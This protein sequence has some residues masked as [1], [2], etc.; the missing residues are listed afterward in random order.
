MSCIEL[1]N[2]VK[3]YG[4]RL[5]VDNLSLAIEAGEI[6]GLLGPNGAGKSTTI[7]ITTGLLKPDSGEV[8][9]ASLNQRTHNVA[10]KRMLGLVP[11][12]IAVYSNFTARE[13][14]EFF[15]SLYGLRGGQLR[16]QAAAALQFVGLGDRQ[17]E[18]AGKFSGGMKRRLNIACAI[19][20]RPKIIIMDEPTVGIDPQSRAHI[21][22][23]IRELAREGATIVYTTHYMEEA[24]ALC[25]RIGIID[26]GK[27]IVVG[28]KPELQKMVASLEKLVLEVG[29]V[30]FTAVEEI[31]Q[32]PY[33]KNVSLSGTRIEV[34]LTDTQDYLQDI[35]SIL[36]R[37]GVRIRMVNVEAPDLES[38]FLSLTG[39]NLRD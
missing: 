3:R 5:A 11:Q 8:E 36:A 10:I 31:K 21:L 37:N 22:E 30:N 38:L 12:E 27:L 33:V 13:N 29:G 35:L 25:T 4:G 20:H 14:A 18:A 24:E 16:E 19:V 26:H 39:R 28:T 9:I 7:K 2:L 32:L 1:R 34:F 17:N 6:F 15:G 23:S